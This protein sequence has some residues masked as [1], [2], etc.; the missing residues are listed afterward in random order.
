MPEWPV[1]R[2][3]ATAMD[4]LFVAIAVIVAIFCCS[5]SK[6]CEEREVVVVCIF[7]LELINLKLLQK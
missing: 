2:E 3:I 1:A 4:G 7:S 5:S 6:D